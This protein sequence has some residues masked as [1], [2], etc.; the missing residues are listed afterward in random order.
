M[1][2]NIFIYVIQIRNLI[3]I[4]IKS[5]LINLGPKNISYTT[6]VKKGWKQEM[7]NELPVNT[8]LDA[9]DIELH[10]EIVSS[11]FSL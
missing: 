9:K 2:L 10:P 8:I 3:S 7:D 5:F 1:N 4:K 6:F 11:F